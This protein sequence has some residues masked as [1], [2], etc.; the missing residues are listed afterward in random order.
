MDFKKIEVLDKDAYDEVVEK[1]LKTREEFEKEKK[2]NRNCSN[3]EVFERD[4]KF[5]RKAIYQHFKK[6]HMEA[7]KHKILYWLLNR[8]YFIENWPS[9]FFDFEPTH[10]QQCV[11]QLL[12]KKAKDIVQKAEKDC[13]EVCEYCGHYISSKSKYSPRCTTRGW[14]AYLCK[15]CADKTGQQYIMDGSVWQDGKEIMTKKQYAEEKAKI[16]ERFKAAQEDDDLEEI[17]DENQD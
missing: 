7:T 11:S 10:K 2:E 1:E 3:V 12:E 14:I 4:G 5:I 15:D 8:R 13:Y 9:R 6:T 17:D 16:E